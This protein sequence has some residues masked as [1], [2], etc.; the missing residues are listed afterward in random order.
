M[1]ATQ[2]SAPP[3]PAT[4]PAIRLDKKRKY[5][6]VHGDRTPEDPHYHVHFWQD[7]LPFGV[8]GK[9]IPDD[10]KRQNTS[11]LDNESKPVLYRPLYD[12]RRAKVLAAKIA[13]MARLAASVKAEEPEEIDE[14]SDSE[15]QAD[16]VKE[17]N[18]ESWLRGEARYEQWMLI[19]AFELQYHHKTRSVAEMVS[20]LVLDEKVVPVAEV[21]ANLRKYLPKDAADPTVRAN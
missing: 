15:A 12:D 13:R 1:S 20:E 5:G 11:G 16:A 8:D 9:L 4:V 6:T 10:N 19:K 7:D 17:V 2:A 3:D 18:F 21:A 14:H